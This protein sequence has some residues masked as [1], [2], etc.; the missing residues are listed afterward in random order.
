M[1]DELSIDILPN[2]SQIVDITGIRLEEWWVV[3]IYLPAYVSGHDWLWRE[4][5]Y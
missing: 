2:S 1:S 3:E 4:R 5:D